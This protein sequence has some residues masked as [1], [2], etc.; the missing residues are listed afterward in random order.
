MTAPRL[1]HWTLATL[2]LTLAGC[3]T[4]SLLNF[5]PVEFNGTYQFVSQASNYSL[6]VK[7]HNATVTQVKDDGV[8]KAVLGGSPAQQFPKK[9]S[10]IGFTALFTPFDGRPDE[11]WT[12]SFSGDEIATGAYTGKLKFRLLATGQNFAEYDCTFAR[13][14]D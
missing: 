3:Q 8:M 6:T 2:A 9:L 11:Q 12:I 7:V 1:T 4:D 13:I 5:T 10:Y 14:G